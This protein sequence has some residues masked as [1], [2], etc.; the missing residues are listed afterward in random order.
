MFV[1]EPLAEGL[2][3]CCCEGFGSRTRGDWL[4]GCPCCDGSV[5]PSTSMDDDMMTDSV[6]R[7]R[8]LVGAVVSC[9]CV[10]KSDDSRGKSPCSTPEA[11]LAVE[12]VGKTVE[13]ISQLEIVRAFPPVSTKSGWP[14]VP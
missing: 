7:G 9:S 5:K 6:V 11:G 12:P 10:S 3:T 2:S 1:S 14:A 8:M 13:E 4:T